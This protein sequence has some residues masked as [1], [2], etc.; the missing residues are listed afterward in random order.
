MA[1]P[2]RLTSK[3]APTTYIGDVIETRGGLWGLYAGRSTDA[4]HGWMIMIQPDGNLISTRRHVMAVFDDEIVQRDRPD[5]GESARS[6]YRWLAKAHALD[7]ARTRHVERVP[8][9]AVTT[10]EPGDVVLD[11]SDPSS[12]VQVLYCHRGHALLQGLPTISHAIASGKVALHAL[13]LDPGGEPVMVE[14]ACVPVEHLHACLLAEYEPLGPAALA[15]VQSWLYLP[16]PGSWV[17]GKVSAR[18][19]CLVRLVSPN[20]WEVQWNG[21]PLIDVVDPDQVEVFGWSAL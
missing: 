3:S 4:R 7:P 10:W 2:R 15:A 16:R 1:S 21:T 11:P 14:R 17:V 13:E 12:V 19:G 8:L 5:N 20:Q 6:V 18:Q 9:P